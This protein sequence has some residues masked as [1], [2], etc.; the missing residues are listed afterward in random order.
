MF[1]FTVTTQRNTYTLEACRFHY[2]VKLD[3]FQFLTCMV[4]V[5]YTDKD[6]FTDV[7]IGKVLIE[8]RWFVIA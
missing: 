3:S 4:Q 2:T 6:V 8:F 7:G 1:S 5:G